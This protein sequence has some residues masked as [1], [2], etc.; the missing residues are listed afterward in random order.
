MN[1]KQFEC[2]SA[3]TKRTKGD[4]GDEEKE[5]TKLRSFFELVG[6]AVPRCALSAAQFRYATCFDVLL[7]FTGT[8]AAVA[9]GVGMPLSAVIFGGL[10]NTFISQQQHVTGINSSRSTVTR[11]PAIGGPQAGG[12]LHTCC[13][14]HLHSTLQPKHRPNSK[15]T[16]HRVASITRYS[17][18]SCS[19][20]AMCRCVC[21]EGE[22]SSQSPP[23]H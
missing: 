15:R 3:T 9:S 21:R 12:T 8:L 5:E 11:A 22:V 17:G 14:R 23:P 6:D 13:V 20:P 1:E 16:R 2:Y 19:L 7:L 10:S 4:T 18:R